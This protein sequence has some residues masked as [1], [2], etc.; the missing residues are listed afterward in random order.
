MD[1]LHCGGFLRDCKCCKC[2]RSVFEQL[3]LEVTLVLCYLLVNGVATAP[4]HAAQ[5]PSSIANLC[6]VMHKV[7]SSVYHDAVIFAVQ[8]DNLLYYT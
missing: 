6:G 2:S 7:W 5:V 3:I 4:I 8:R 1:F